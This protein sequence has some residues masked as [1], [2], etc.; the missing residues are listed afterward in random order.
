MTGTTRAIHAAAVLQLLALASIQ[1]TRAFGPAP[2][3]PGGGSSRREFVDRAAT[4]VISSAA[5]LL[6]TAR[7]ANAADVDT[8]NFLKTGMVSMPM[9]V[10]G[11]AGKARPV[12]GVMLRDGSEV[13]RDERGG[14]VLA[15]ILLPAATSSKSSATIPVVASFVS[16]WALAKGGQFDVEC[17]DSTTG[18]GAFLAVTSAVG[19]TGTETGTNDVSKLPNSFFVDSLFSSTGRFSFYGT[20]TDIRV[21]KSDT[22]GGYRYLEITFSNLSQSTNAEI[23]RTA[24]VAATIPDGSDCVVMLVGSS[25]TN[26]WKNKGS[27]EKV[28][29]VVESFRATLAPASGMK[30]RAR[31]RAESLS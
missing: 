25:T 9:G 29:G 12:T 17:R 23:P 27:D 8:E 24:L 10:S 28:R 4:L 3:P 7:L 22:N 20:P 19:S 1:N 18:D 6:P 5:V 21:R 31:G 11:Q 26:R 14:G 13:S 30:A 2:R 15:E 16:P